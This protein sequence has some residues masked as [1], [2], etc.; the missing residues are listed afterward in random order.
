MGFAGKQRGQ[1]ESDLSILNRAFARDAPGISFSFKTTMRLVE[2]ASP[3][4]A[5]IS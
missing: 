4:P 3:W 5:P 2:K 1:R